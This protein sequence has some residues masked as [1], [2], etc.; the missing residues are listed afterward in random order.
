MKSVYGPVASWRLGRS[1][2]IDP[3]CSERKIC[4]FDCTYCQLG[5][6]SKI[7]ERKNFIS[8]KKLKEDLKAIRN[9]EADVITFSGTGE[10]TLAKNLE[11]MIDYV[12]S[13]SDLPL[14]ILTNSSFLSSEATRKILNKMDIVVAK[15]DA[16][17]ESLFWKINRPH[18]SIRFENY[19][20]GIRKFREGYAGKLALQIMFIDANKARAGDIAEIATG[21]EPDEVQLNTPL[22][23][24]K[25]KPLGK[26]RL[27]S[28]KDI[29]SDFEN[30]LS[31]YDSEKP[32]VEP[33]DMEEVRKRKRP[34]P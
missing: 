30:V 16:P 23:P 19:L 22:R 14:A 20:E 17:N 29:F 7:H 4:S 34:E 1:L 32:K 6:G 27:E 24:C 10:P 21:L 5:S 15:L 33:L 25:V 11:A 18:G 8:M 28:I 3:V 9:A 26:E 12:R 31:V 2:G 13:I